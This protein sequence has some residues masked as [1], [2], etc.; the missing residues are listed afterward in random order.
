MV[1]RE[2]V[3]QLAQEV[4]RLHAF[5][6]AIS[7]SGSRALFMDRVTAHRLTR[8]QPEPGG[9]PHADQG[10]ALYRASDGCAC[11]LH[12]SAAP[13]ERFVRLLYGMVAVA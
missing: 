1:R 2:K 11:L 6:S 12:K 13:A 3:A 7:G 4:F 8:G 9:P 5:V 10:G